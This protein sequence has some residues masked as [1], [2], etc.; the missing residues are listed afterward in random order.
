MSRNSIH[1]HPKYEPQNESLKLHV[2]YLK[3]RMNYLCFGGGSK[4]YE[5]LKLGVKYKIHNSNLIL[6]TFCHAWA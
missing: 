1:I 4:I 6:N 3:F 5:I 2:S